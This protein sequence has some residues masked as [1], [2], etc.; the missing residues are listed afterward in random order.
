MPFPASRAFSIALPL[1]DCDDG[2]VSDT[3]AIRALID[4]QVDAFRRKDAAAAIALLDEQ[5]VAFEMI[6]PLMLP[7]GAA[8]DEQAMAAWFASWDGPI[9]IEI[10]DLAIHVDGDVAF[11]HSLNRLGGTRTSGRQT[12][13]W[14]RSTLGFRRAAGG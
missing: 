8:R 2:A 10:R 9:T 1:F 6:A 4:A 11:S 7:A 14:M 13:I 3:E 12:D 5:V